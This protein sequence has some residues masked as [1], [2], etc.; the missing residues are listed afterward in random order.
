MFDSILHKAPVAPVR[1]NPDLPTKLEDIINK[2]LEKDRNLRYQHASEM[3][4]DLQRVK[5]DT[6]SQR[7]AVTGSAISEG[8]AS[9]SA[10][11]PVISTS[12]AVARPPEQ[13]VDSLPARHTTWLY[14]VL[15][16]VAALAVLAGTL[17]Y[18]RPA[19]TLTEKDSIL[20]TDFVNSTG[21]AVFD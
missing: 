5:R 8:P 13:F 7:V 1:L 14:L 12:R 15:T 21:E 19:K 4:T 20:V 2:A 18:K 3:R 10:P 17:L 11:M 6:D 16:G 9:M